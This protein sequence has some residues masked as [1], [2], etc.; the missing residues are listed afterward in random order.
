MVGLALV[1]SASR[2]ALVSDSWEVVGALPT[3]AGA[4]AAADAL[5]AEKKVNEERIA[6]LA[7]AEA[8]IKA[9]EEAANAEPSKE[10]PEA[11]TK[12]RD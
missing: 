3:W 9:E 10:E 11:E 12:R 4:K 1:A 6:K 2:S 8:A 7:E 5:A